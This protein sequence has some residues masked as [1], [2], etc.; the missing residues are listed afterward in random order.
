M[1]SDCGG[2]LDEFRD[3]PRALRY[4]DCLAAAEISAGFGG[5]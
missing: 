4:H 5:A 2:A 3:H 1:V